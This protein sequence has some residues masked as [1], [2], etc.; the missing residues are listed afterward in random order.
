[1]DQFA[2][3]FDHNSITGD[4]HAIIGG[5]NSTYFSNADGAPAS[6]DR[7]AI[8]RRKQFD[9]WMGSVIL[10]YGWICWWSSMNRKFLASMGHHIRT[11]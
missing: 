6:M 1:L 7:E 5:I 8:C 11:R 4:E 2:F 3:G 10:I 9:Q